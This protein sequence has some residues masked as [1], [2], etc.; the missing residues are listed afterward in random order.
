MC[1]SPSGKPCDGEPRPSL[2]GVSGVVMFGSSYNVEHADEQPFI[3]EARE[4]TLDAI[5]RGIPYLGVC[6]GAQLLAW[7][8]DAPVTKAPVREVGFEP[9]RPTAGRARRPAARSL[10]RRR[11]GLPVAHGH[12]RAAR[13]RDA[14]S[15]RAIA[16]A[17][18]AYRVG[19]RTW[20][21]QFHFEIVRAEMDEWLDVVRAGRRSA[22]GVV[23]QVCRRRSGT[24]PIAH[25]AGHER[26]GTEVFDAVR[27]RRRPDAVPPRRRATARSW[28]WWPTTSR[29]IGSPGGPTADT[30]CPRPTSMRSGDRA[31]VPRSS[32]PG[33]PVAPEQMLEPFDGLL[34]VGGGDVDPARYGAEPDTVHDYGVEPDRDAF[35]IDLAA[36]GRA[37][38]ACRRSASVAACRS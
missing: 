23:G 5:E 29:P 26:R 20:G 12:V 1:P 38:C 11:P 6:F 9:V 8:L 31:L 17:N 4:L 2:D 14:C 32:R 19:D 25:L 13:G 34:L 24:R 37:S 16:C 36:R 27:R 18:Q 3:K 35:E 15:S 7:S 30:A 21:V 22:R 28:P 33:E 10:R